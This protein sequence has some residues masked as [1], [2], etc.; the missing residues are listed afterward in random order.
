M[1]G[2]CHME[3]F[4][5]LLTKPS[6]K[7]WARLLKPFTNSTKSGGG[8][9]V[10]L[11]LVDVLNV[12]EMTAQR[13][14]GHLSVFYLGASSGPAPLHRQDCSHWCLPGVPDA[15]NELLYYLILKRADRSVITWRTS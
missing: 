1:G 7:P 5:E 9:T 11:E 14:D 13:K 6:T 3:T 2:S 8:T 10:P 15:W 12:T 4:P